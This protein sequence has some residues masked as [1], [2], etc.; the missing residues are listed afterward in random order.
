MTA[1]KLLR[2]ISVSLILSNIMTY[3]QSVD[4]GD[5]SPEEYVD[6][7]LAS[8]K[9]EIP[10]GPDIDCSRVSRFSYVKNYK[11]SYVLK[12]D[13]QNAIC[14]SI[15]RYDDFIF[16]DLNDFWQIS[17]NFGVQVVLID[18]SSELNGAYGQRPILN[19]QIMPKFILFHYDNIEYSLNMPIWSHEYGHAV[20]GNFIDEHFFPLSKSSMVKKIEFY[21]SNNQITQEL[22]RL[23]RKQDHLY[24]ERDR[25]SNESE[26]AKQNGDSDK[27]DM[28]EKEREIVRK[29][30]SKVNIQHSLLDNKFESL[31]EGYFPYI[32]F[33]SG[34]YHEFFADVFAGLYYDDINIV[35]NNFDELGAVFSKISDYRRFNPTKSHTDADS[36]ANYQT[37]H[38]F[39]PSRHFLGSM[40]ISVLNTKEKKKEFI[41]RLANFILK[42]IQQLIENGEADDFL[43][44]GALEK[45][46][47]SASSYQLIKNRFEE[48]EKESKFTT[49]LSLHDLQSYCQE[50][51]LECKDVIISELRLK[52]KGIFKLAPN[53]S[54][55]NRR[56]SR[57]IKEILGSF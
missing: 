33:Y 21:S 47:S 37:H 29:K 28:L 3:A 41:K 46:I 7:L 36:W 55:S 4:I 43:S 2:I 38:F 35:G 12:P 49:R 44:Y 23:S 18:D 34:P 30:L 48:M 54:K 32:S 17:D 50:S 52:K 56:L 53:I 5:M 22:D 15:I 9:D 27:L 6:K 19:K 16:D 42:D 25:L 45:Y 51:F 31:T 57:A 40:D 20:L 14:E 10:D 11:R 13:S 26:E 24:D 1:F 8:F 39:T